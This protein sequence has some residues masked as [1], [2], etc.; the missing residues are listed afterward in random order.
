[1]RRDRLQGS[2]KYDRR[3]MAKEA[4]CSSTLGSRLAAAAVP[5]KLPVPVVGPRLLPI[6][7][8]PLN[9]VPVP[10]VKVPVVPMP[11]VPLPVVVPA[12]LHASREE[13]YFCYHA[14]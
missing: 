13:K 2:A 5:S 9:P 6:P 3:R 14:S 12:A 10:G 7:L 4:A 11:V 1:M 8:V